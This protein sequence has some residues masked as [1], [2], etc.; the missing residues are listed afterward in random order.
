M[1]STL[2]ALPGAYDL[3]L[4][5]ARVID[6]A[7]GTDAVLDVAVTGGKIAAVGPDL[8]CPAGA[9]RLDLSGAIVTPGLIDTHAHIYEHVTGDFGLNPDLVGVRGGVTTVVDQGGPS[10]L[11]FNGFRNSSSSHRAAESSVSFQPT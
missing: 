1:S 9:T 3:V 7:N 6:P 2:S 4:K 5:G 11:T 10:P 8:P